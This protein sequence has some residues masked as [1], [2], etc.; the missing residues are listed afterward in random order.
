[1][2]RLT[3]LAISAN[4]ALTFAIMILVVAA[5]GI[6]TFVKLGFIEQSSNWDKPHLPGAGNRGCRH[7][8]H[9]RSG[10]VDATVTR[11]YAPDFI[12]AFVA[13]VGR[14]LTPKSRQS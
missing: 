12:N 8:K 10:S 2:N 14:H 1:M 11:N 6:G 5:V 3:N 7:G 13:A 9:G 4:L